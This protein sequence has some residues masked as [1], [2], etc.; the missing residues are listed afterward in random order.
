MQAGDAREKELRFMDVCISRCKM[1]SD[2]YARSSIS[3]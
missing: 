3:Q 1:L 2:I